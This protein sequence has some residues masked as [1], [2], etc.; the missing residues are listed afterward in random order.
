M[1][2]AIAPEMPGTWIWLA[3]VPGA[4]STVRVMRSPVTSTTV[5]EC[6]SAAAGSATTPRPTV[7]TI[8]AMI[9]FRL[10][11]LKYAS[12]R[13]FLRICSAFARAP[14]QAGHATERLVPLQLEN[15]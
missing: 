4:T 6:S 5:T 9:P 15:G 2:C 12:P 7:A 1:I 10:F 8:T 3:G 14:G 13:A 11:I